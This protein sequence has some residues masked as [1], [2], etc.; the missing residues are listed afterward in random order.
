[1]PQ[2][3]RWAAVCWILL[4]LLTACD[5]E[6]QPDPEPGAIDVVV[7]S[8]AGAEGAALI[9]VDAAISGATAPGGEAFARPAGASTRVAVVRTVA[10]E[11]RVRFEVPDV[12]R[13]P[14]MRL[15]QVAGPDDRLRADLSGYRLEVER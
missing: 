8:P 15:L 14:T 3:W 2:R 13:P 11:L 5:D 7:A 9:E 12:H 10:G 1:M 6:V 4:S